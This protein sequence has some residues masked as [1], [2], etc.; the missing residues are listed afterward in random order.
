MLTLYQN[1]IF[2]SIDKIII[3]VL[4]VPLKNKFIS[5]LSKEMQTHVSAVGTFLPLHNKYL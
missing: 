5:S 2:I 4:I 1:V 3:S